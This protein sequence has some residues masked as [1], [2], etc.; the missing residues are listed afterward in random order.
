M[1]LVVL[2][3]QMFLRQ[4]ILAT[5]HAT[6]NRF[7]YNLWF[8]ENAEFAQAGET[9]LSNTWV[10]ITPKFLME[11]LRLNMISVGSFDDTF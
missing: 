6:T 2:I 5:R 1:P 11:E 10:E 8:G 7:T 4:I 9:L 3:V